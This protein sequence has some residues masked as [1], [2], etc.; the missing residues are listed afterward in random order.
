M[1]ACTASMLPQVMLPSYVLERD[2]EG[3]RVH[4]QAH[5]LTEEIM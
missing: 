3:A 1:A 2:P 5:N 4:L